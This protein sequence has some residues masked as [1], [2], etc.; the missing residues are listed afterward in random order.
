[1]EDGSTFLLLSEAAER[2]GLLQKLLSET[3]EGEQLRLTGLPAGATSQCVERCL[4]FCMQ[5]YLENRKGTNIQFMFRLEVCSVLEVCR[6]ASH[7]EMVPL[8]DRCVSFIAAHIDQVGALDCL[9]VSLLTRI[10]KRVPLQ[11]LCALEG[12]VLSRPTACAL[13]EA[14]APLTL[15]IW[16]CA[17]ETEGWEPHRNHEED[18][19]WNAALWEEK[20][21]PVEVSK[22]VSDRLER[23]LWRSTWAQN[24]MIALEASL[25][26][27]TE[28]IS[29]VLLFIQDCQSAIHQH[30]PKEDAITVA[31]MTWKDYCGHFGC[32]RSLDLSN[33]SLSSSDVPEIAHFIATHTHVHTLILREAG[34]S[35]ELAA[36][37][38]RVVIAAEE[39][40]H[41]KR[42]DLSGNYISAAGI[43]SIS[44]A[45]QMSGLRA[46]RLRRNFIGREFYTDNGQTYLSPS[47][48]ER[49]GLATLFQ[50]LPKATTLQ[51][52]DASSN[53]IH[54]KDVSSSAWAAL[55]QRFRSKGLDTLDLSHNNLAANSP[56]DCLEADGDTA[57]DQLLLLSRMG[58][59]SLAVEGCGLRG[60]HME[61]LLV[62]DGVTASG[63][64]LES[65]SS[66]MDSLAISHNPVGDQGILALAEAA[67]EIQL[68]SLLA[69]D[70]DVSDEGAAGLAESLASYG[71]M[72]QIDVSRNKLS[73]KGIERLQSVVINTVRAKAAAM[74]CLT[75]KNIPFEVRSQIWAYVWK[76]AMLPRLEVKADCNNMSDEDVADVAR[77]HAAAKGRTA[78]SC[79]DGAGAPAPKAY[80]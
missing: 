77:L 29:T 55:R 48:P 61:G 8:V 23:G 69:S 5:D 1:M 67:E 17:C 60:I 62:Q 35:D 28:T 33:R 65:A 25:A 24:K 37:L 3:N 43:E 41:L 47:P 36:S 31:G 75:R 22:A 56:D 40:R 57:V 39:C 7:L 45:C 50:A 70:V 9:S 2:S 66:P 11:K 13:E 18:S 14:L 71:F 78:F 21:R 27:G 32:L 42:I 59:R 80:Y 46:L 44:A 51:F 63:L 34:I 15:S 19:G 58:V 73:V 53:R 20:H 64:V 4:E 72:R 26:A 38:S 74:I 54:L 16:K 49:G 6:V 68:S 79:Q 12:R 30:A 10:I 76:S 52:I